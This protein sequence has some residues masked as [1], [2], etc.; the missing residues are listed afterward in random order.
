VVGAEGLPP[1][2]FKSLSE[3][4]LQLAL[5]LE[6][7]VGRGD[8]QGASHKAARLQFLDQ[9]PSHDGFPGAGIVGEQEGNTGHLEKVT[10]DRLKLVWERIDPSDGEREVG[11]VLVSERETLGLDAESEQARV[12]VEGFAQRRKAKL[13]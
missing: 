1:D 3:L 2:H 12:A 9:Q 6:G 11:V 5:P 4:V 13:S 7:Q 10:V 8:D